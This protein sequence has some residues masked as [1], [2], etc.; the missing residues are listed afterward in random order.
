MDITIDKNQF[1]N[2]Y[3]A[4]TET[5]YVSVIGNLTGKVV[6]V[7][8]SVNTETILGLGGQN[9]LL[10]IDVMVSKKSWQPLKNFQFHHLPVKS[11]KKIKI[12]EDPDPE[13]KD[14]QSKF[15]TNKEMNLLYVKIGEGRKSEYHVN[16]D[17]DVIFEIDYMNVLSGIWFLN[18]KE[19]KEC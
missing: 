4:D 16:R 18:I 15:F 11:L 2:I 19:C 13:K 3:C 14:G 17:A 5:L 12:I 8:P 1:E 6:G 9:D 7:N 10:I